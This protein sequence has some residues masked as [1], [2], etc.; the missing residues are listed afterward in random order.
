M[1]ER[2]TKLH[3]ICYISISEEDDISLLAI[4]TEDGRILFY[5][6]RPDDLVEAPAVDGKDAPLPSAK[7][8][9]QLGG[10]DATVL[11][12]IKDFAILK[13]EDKTEDFII[14]TG[15]SDGSVK[16]WRLSVSDL[17]K[18]KQK[19]ANQVGSLIG[20]YE[21]GNRITCLA[22]FV[23]IPLPEGASEV[24]EEDE[25]DEEEN[26]DEDVSSSDSE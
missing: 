26:E 22:A 1:P 21:T 9:A 10:K 12:R 11:G 16:L 7:L 25:L 5:S 19:K 17:Q 3:K 8:V 14:V 15:G 4:S 13:L 18:T 24:V 23:M 20:T 2:K 6:T